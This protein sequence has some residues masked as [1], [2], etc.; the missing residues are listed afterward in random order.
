MENIRM[1]LTYRG[2]F[3]ADFKLRS[4]ISKEGTHKP[5]KWL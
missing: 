3:Q 4:D 1:E 2:Q 5:H